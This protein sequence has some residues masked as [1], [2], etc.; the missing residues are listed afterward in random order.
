MALKLAH[1]CILTKDLEKT[2]QF[3]CGVLGFDKVFEFKKEGSLYGYY[4]RMCDK[5][6]VE[7]FL[8]DEFTHKP[9]AFL[10]LCLETDDID[11]YIERL[12]RGGIKTTEKTK[13]CDNTLQI[14]FKDPSGI[15]IEL[16]QYT[17]KSSQITGVDCE[18]DW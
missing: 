11:S 16:H 9:S 17:D 1:V 3:Y 14:W 15:D 12:K 10:H 8:D 4:L 7:V 13:G 6:Y 5:N 2:E 18:V